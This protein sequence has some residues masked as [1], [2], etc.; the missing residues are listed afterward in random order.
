MPMRSFDDLQSCRQYDQ[1]FNTFKGRQ[2]FQ[3]EW[4]LMEALLVPS[5]GDR[6]LD[7]G[8]GAG[9]HLLE[10]HGSGLRCMGIDASIHMVELARGR[11]GPA[12][13]VKHG[14][15]ESLPFPDDHFDIVVFNKT[16]EFLD[17]PVLALKEARRVA[18]KNVFVQVV[19]PFSPI[20]LKQAL[21][22]LDKRFPYHPN[23]YLDLWTLKK[24]IA[25]AMGHALY[26]WASTSTE[27]IFGSWRQS[28]PHIS[29][30]PFGDLVAIRVDLAEAV[31]KTVLEFTYRKT[32]LTA[33]IHGA[34]REGL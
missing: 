11:L 24:L 16:L 29:T 27:P 10:W 20:G 33:L 8:C 26:Q 15:A 30:S 31:S 23:H 12:V 19:N 7:V 4:E 34:T 25:S 17:N 5:P 2:W 18:R 3:R 6:L 22:F 14:F 13:P 9:R 1:W 21:R 28:G 32:A